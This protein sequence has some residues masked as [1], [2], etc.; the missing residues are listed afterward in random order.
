MQF[1]AEY[2]YVS[3]MLALLAG[4]GDAPTGVA[5][6]DMTTITDD[7][8]TRAARRTRELRESNTRT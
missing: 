3:W 6:S 7:A 1:G 2:V 8:R 4:H 5:G